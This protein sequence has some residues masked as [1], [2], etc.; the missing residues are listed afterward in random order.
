MEATQEETVLRIV[1]DVL[2]R[3]NLGLDDDLFDNGGTSLSFV[4]VLAGV[5]QE[6]HVVVHPADLGGTAT[7]RGIAACAAKEPA[8]PATDS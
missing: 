6:L 4:R 2:G 7:A 5:K 3:P 1:R 8:V